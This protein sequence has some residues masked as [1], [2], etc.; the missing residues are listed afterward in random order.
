MK[1]KIKIISLCLISFFLFQAA[2]AQHPITPARLANSVR[3]FLENAIRVGVVLAFFSLVYGGFLYLSSAG[4][5]EQI[6]KAKKQIFGVF[7]GLILLLG[8]WLFLGVFRPEFGGLSPAEIT[9]IIPTPLPSLEKPEGA[10]MAFAEIPIETFLKGEENGRVGENSNYFNLDELREVR[11]FLANEFLPLTDEIENKFEELEEIVNTQCSCGK[12]SSSGGEHLCEKSGDP[13]SCPVFQDTCWA[14]KC[15]G[16]PCEGAREAMGEKMAEIAALLPELY[17]RTDELRERTLPIKER[18]ARLSFAL[19]TM[20]DCPFDSIFSRDVFAFA[21]DYLRKTAPDVDWQISRIPLF[22]N[23]ENPRSNSIADF[24][25][26]KTGFHYLSLSP[27]AVTK[28]G[29]EFWGIPTVAWDIQSW[30]DFFTNLPHWEEV[31][32]EAEEATTVPALPQ[33]ELSPEYQLDISCPFSIPFGEMMEE[34]LAALGDLINS[35]ENTINSASSLPTDINDYYQ[36]TFTECSPKNCSPLC[37][38]NPIGC[39]CQC[40][41]TGLACSPALDAQ[42][43]LVGSKFGGIKDNN[44]QI[45][46][47][48]SKIEQWINDWEEIEKEVRKRE[49]PLTQT[50]IQELYS[51]F[52]DS[53]EIVAFEI[54]AS[55][56]HYCLAHAMEVEAGWMLSPCDEYKEGCLTPEGKRVEGVEDCKCENSEECRSSYPVLASYQCRYLAPAFWLAEFFGFDTPKCHFYNYFCCRPLEKK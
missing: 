16:D 3:N 56:M 5:V 4:K 37:D 21:A 42:A 13:P 22:E 36:L 8:G 12:T 14:E 29:A 39:L 10:Y 15:T 23:I 47:L 53:K 52:P 55:R 32:R 46:S 17:E 51:E 18:M 38:C 30:I 54:M 50:E 41:C 44:N 24:Y 19:K 7:I 31:L 20:K 6:A 27:G 35:L 28:A 25:C 33:L 34:F 40:F 45:N 11:D 26:P 48:I 1:R 9:Q 43:G 49:R 2:S